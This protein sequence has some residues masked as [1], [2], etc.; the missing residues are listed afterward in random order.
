M[1]DKVLHFSLTDCLHESR[2]FKQAITVSSKLGMLVHVFGLNDHDKSLLE[3]EDKKNFMIYRVSLVSSDLPKNTIFQLIKYFEWFFRAFYFAIKFRP[4]FIVAHTPAILPLCV[5]YKCVFFKTTIIYDAHE[6]EFEK[7]GLTSFRKKAVIC[8]ESACLPFVNTVQVVGK[9][10]YN[11]YVKKYPKH[12]KK[13][14]VIMNVPNQNL[15]NKTS[16]LRDKFSISLDKKIYLYQ[17]GVSFGRNVDIIVKAFVRL[18]RDDKSKDVLVIMG[19]GDLK[20]QLQSLASDCN[21]IFFHD[22][23]PHEDLMSYTSSADYGFCLYD[24]SCVNHIYCCPNKVFEYVQA[25]IPIVIHKGLVELSDISKQFALGYI[26]E[27]ATVDSIVNFVVSDKPTINISTKAKTE[28]SWEA[29]EPKVL[30]RYN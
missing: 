12:K 27:S 19:D 17:G 11:A 16:M 1:N 3:R 8:L 23:V 18:D 21:N 24:D 9:H 28:L 7:N 10:I 22:A 15:Q 4:S 25:G 13:F 29:Y 14:K 26:L 30:E 5:L 20:P 2:L 6:L